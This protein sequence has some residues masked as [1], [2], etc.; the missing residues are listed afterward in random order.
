[1]LLGRGL[2][3]RGQLLRGH[4]VQ[5]GADIGQPFQPQPTVEC[6]VHAEIEQ[7]ALRGQRRNT[8]RTQVDPVLTHLLQTSVGRQERVS[9]KPPMEI[10][11][12]A[13]RGVFI[14]KI[15]LVR[16][17]RPQPPWGQPRLRLETHVAL[18]FENLPG[19]E[20]VLLRDQQIDVTGIAQRRILKGGDGQRNALE[21]PKIDLLL[22]EEPMQSDQ[23]RG[24]VQAKVGIGHAAGT[25]CCG[26]LVRHVPGREGVKVAREERDHLMMVDDLEQMRPTDWL[27][28]KRPDAIAVDC[29]LWPAKA[30]QHKIKFR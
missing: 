2:R 30:S 16:E 22:A 1:M 6:S 27:L 26:L 19:F 12:H 8:L 25:Q 29:F 3:C 14:G 28:R 4:G 15:F 9:E 17:V 11:D 13:G 10:D 21:N 24:T 18:R 20:D 5:Q 7:Q 23:M